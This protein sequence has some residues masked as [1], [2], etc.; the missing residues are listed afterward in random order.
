MLA[1]KFLQY[2]FLGIFKI[3][4]SGIRGYDS[5]D[6]LYTLSIVLT[7]L[8]PTDTGQNISKLFTLKVFFRKDLLNHVESKKRI[9]FIEITIL[10]NLFEQ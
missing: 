2:L 7:F 8:N 5:V 1:D 6:Y 9:L 3:S 10:L 4:R